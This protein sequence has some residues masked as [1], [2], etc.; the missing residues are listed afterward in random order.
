MPFADVTP[1]LAGK[2]LLIQ[3]DSHSIAR[4]CGEEVGMYWNWTRTKGILSHM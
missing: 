3:S 4:L 2:D 1:G